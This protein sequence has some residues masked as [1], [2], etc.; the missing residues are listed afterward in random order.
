MK[1]TRIYKYMF[2][3][4]LA[5][6]MVVGMAACSDLLET[7]GTHDLMDKEL[8]QK[9][10]SMFM[11]YGI[12]QCMQQLA[13]QYVVAGEMRGDLA[14]TTCYSSESLRTMAD[15]SATAG[16][17]YTTAYT[18]YSVINNCNYYIAH[19]DTT[20]MTGSTNVTMNEYAA[21][22]AFR[23]WAY[24]MLVRNYG[25]VPFFTEPLTKISEINSN[26]YPVLNLTGIVSRL[27]P[28]LEQYAGFD[29]PDYGSIA[30]GNTNLGQSKTASSK[31]CFI[32]VDV[33]LGEMYLE[34]GQ[35]ERAAKHYIDYIVNNK[36]TTGNRTSS[37]QTAQWSPDFMLPTDFNAVSGSAWNTFFSNNATDDII[38]YI[39]M[40]VN[41]LRGTVT[42]IPKLFGYDYYA[43]TRDSLY[44]DAIQIAPSSVY[45][46]LADSS[47]YYYATDGFGT[48]VKSVRMGDMRRA[49]TLT[50]LTFED[51]TAGSTTETEGNASTGLPVMHKYNNA[52]IVLYRTTTV[53]LHLAEALNRMGYSD[54]A[55]AILK[56]GIDRQLLS[57]P[58]MSETSKTAL[59]ERFSLLSADNIAIFDPA[60]GSVQTKVAYGIHKHGCGYTN[61]VF[62]PY[63]YG[64]L[65]QA[66]ASVL[67][68]KQDTI[69]TMEEMLC[70]EYAMEF[71]FEGS[72]FADLCRMARHRNMVTAGEGSKWLAA[73][74]A[75]KNPT[76]DLTDEKNWYLPYK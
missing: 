36:L 75:F 3:G 63:Q 71:A 57:A 68:T 23:A 7:D 34:D 10:D 9:T 48:T 4:V 45:T 19:R 66:Y 20:L 69:D 39:P 62:S 61:G 21:V 35:Y 30:C 6:S 60:V 64:T 41:R 33:I 38:T 16:N 43:T 46:T 15:F 59:Q 76:K 18:Y 25:E 58:Y 67:Q 14:V 47:D 24:L 32:P 44:P 27:A 70:D 73:K 5:F 31:L 40:S 2:K 37:V 51:A 55:F 54:I 1:A 56:D 52:N 26:S 28:D 50:K 13:D 11:A 72:R 8:S 12:M 29:V 65:L 17:E 49:A 53:Y 74:L 42:K 22:K